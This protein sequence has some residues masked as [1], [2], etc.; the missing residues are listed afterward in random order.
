LTAGGVPP[1]KELHADYGDRVRFFDVLVR[2]AHPGERRGPYDAFDQKLADA[3]AHRRDEELPWPVLADDLDG[4]THRA[5]GAMADPTYLLD[6][7]G[8]VAFY[9]MWTH[10]P[11]LRRA[12]DELL[13][14]GGTGAPV[15]GGIDRSPHVA[16]AIAAGWHALTRGGRRAVIDLE[17]AAPT[18]AALIYLGHLVRPALAPLALRS[19]PLPRP[20]GFALAG[21]VLAVAVGLGTSAVRRGHG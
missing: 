14:Q 2:Q 20:V 15:A 11:T 7:D 8:R 21:G 10:A 1:L 16:T 19:A 6:A 18:S 4:S 9:S 5:Y 13:A 12:I 3:A 17:L